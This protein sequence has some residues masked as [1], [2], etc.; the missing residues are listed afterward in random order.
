MDRKTI[1][2]I[3]FSI[4]FILAWDKY[5]V[6]KQ[7]P[8]KQEQ[9]KKVVQESSKV[10]TD[11]LSS[12]KESGKSAD[13]ESPVLKSDITEDE[14]KTFFQH[15]ENI[16]QQTVVLE[17]P[18][19]KLTFSN[20]GGVLTS[21]LL[22]NYKNKE[23][24]NIEL[25]N[26]EMARRGYYPFAFSNND[27]QILNNKMFKVSQSDN[28]VIFTYS[29]GST[30]LEKK[31]E[32]AKNGYNI[33]FSLNNSLNKDIEVSLGP[34][35]KS[36]E[37][38]K[39]R[40]SGIQD[41]IVLFS[42]NDLEK[43]EKKK[44][45]KNLDK[46]L[47]VSW[48]AV[49][50]RYFTKLVD[51]RDFGII[52]KFGIQ[53]Y[54]EGEHEF[55]L[56]DLI[57]KA[58]NGQVF[59]IFMGPKQYEVLKSFNRGYEKTVDFGFFGLFGKWLFFFLRW[60]NGFVHNYGWSIVIMTIIIRAF[61]F[62]LNQMSMK[63]MKRM[64]ELQP[65]IKEIQAKYKKYG[66]DNTMKMKMNQE[67]AELYKK[68]G[69]NPAGGCLPMLVQMP[70]FFAIWGVLLSLIDLQN[71]PFIFWIT[72]LSSKDPYYVLPVLMGATQFISQLITPTT[73][74]KNQKMMMYAMPVVITV[75]LANAPSGLMVYWTTNNL[76]QV[77]QQLI[78]NYQSKKEQS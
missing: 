45:K 75:M 12:G 68:E 70:V 30:V 67:I 18:F 20:K 69:V 62:P 7:L 27:F 4:A 26:R 37:K 48:G 9:T 61:L 25:V 28:L 3:L 54:F 78:I 15:D 19:I 16:E 59:S 60:I 31:F 63:S 6:K 58:P 35:I 42:D 36:A 10:I 24:N 44:I 64:G 39:S 72:D 34:G 5:V 66:S 41:R 76:F 14:A 57:F 51:N 55:S 2:A 8:Q 52:V 29:A 43:Y 46:S 13:N 71:A 40:Y 22:K 65:K 53:K 17:N 49:E 11:N 50:D 77:V 73:G 38:V 23:G 32:L 33:I 56:S 1:I 21:A 74:D 47:K